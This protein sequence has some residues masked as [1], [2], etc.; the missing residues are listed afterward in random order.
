[1]ANIPPVQRGS[2]GL[3][4][5]E[6]LPFA[7]QFGLRF[8]LASNPSNRLIASGM[9]VQSQGHRRDFSKRGFSLR[10]FC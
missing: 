2:L 1:M 10:K 5:F 7:K 3:T 8:P 4:G 9:R 6:K